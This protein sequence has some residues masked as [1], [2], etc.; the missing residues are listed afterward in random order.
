[1]LSLKTLFTF[2]RFLILMAGASF[3]L[4]S[5]RQRSSSGDPAER[6]KALAHQYCQSCHILPEP[7]LLDKKTWIEGVLPHMGPRLGIF[8]FAGRKY[9]SDKTKMGVP[10]NFYPDH[11]QLTDEQWSDLL[12]F[13]S[14]AAPDSLEG[15]RRKEPISMHNGQFSAMIPQKNYLA[16][17]ST[18]VAIDT[19]GR[20]IIQAD[21]LQR[22]IYVYSDKLLQVD[23][24]STASMVVDAI[25]EKDKLIVCN[26]GIIN[27]HARCNSSKPT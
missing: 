9:P 2:L 16:P 19:I 22:M 18:Y 14:S 26:I 12:S 1:M 27:P 21:G 20:K 24:A 3:C 15:Q 13:Y 4:C 25:R 11:P 17:V 23:S 6:G 10:S 5:C 7:G 8:N